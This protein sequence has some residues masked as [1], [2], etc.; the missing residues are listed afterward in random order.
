MRYAC[1]MVKRESIHFIIRDKNNKEKKNDDI[2]SS[3]LLSKNFMQTT[4]MCN[5]VNVYAVQSLSA[6]H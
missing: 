1:V 3:S 6:S 5:Y 4:W 2:N